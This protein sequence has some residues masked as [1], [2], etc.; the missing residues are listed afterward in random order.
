MLPHP[1][2]SPDFAKFDFNIFESLQ[3]YLRGQKFENNE[4]LKVAVVSWIHQCDA[5]TS[6]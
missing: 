3:N 1:P 6:H 5:S 4:A 2:Y